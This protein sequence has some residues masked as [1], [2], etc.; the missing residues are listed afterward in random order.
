MISAIVVL[1]TALI[2]FM[3]GIVGGLIL[4]WFVK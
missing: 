4:S 2:S 3:L 1:G